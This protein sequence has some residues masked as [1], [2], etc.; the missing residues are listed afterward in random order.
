MGSV[1]T[2]SVPDMEVHAGNPAQFV[3]YRQLRA[4]KKGS[5]YGRSLNANR[6]S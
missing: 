6:D 5:L 2:K 4:R 1:V 3:K